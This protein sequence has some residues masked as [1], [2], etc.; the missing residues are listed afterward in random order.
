MHSLW[1]RFEVW[2][3]EHW[4]EGLASLNAPATDEQI[5]RLQE[6]LGLTLPDDY[7]ACLKIHNGQAANVGGIFEG[8]EFL[9][10]DEIL[11]QWTIWKDL[12]DGGDFIGIKSD[13]SN[14]VRDDWWNVS[15]IPF[16][17]NGSGDHLCLD[18]APHACGSSGQVITM[19]HDS[20]E[21]ELLAPNFRSWFNSYLKR[22]FSGDVVYSDEYGGLINSEDA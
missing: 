22:V 19:W 16:T 7:V 21:R 17:Y 18:L 10:T 3:A 13:P 9:S 6:A 15:W 2:L 5:A 11:A 12:L 4:P 1:T 14:G 20:S 8:S